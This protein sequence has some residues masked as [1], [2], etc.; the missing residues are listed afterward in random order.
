MK[1]V[2]IPRPRLFQTLETKVDDDIYDKL[3]DRKLYVVVG[4]GNTPYIYLRHQGVTMALARFVIGVEQHDSLSVD[5]I[6]RDTLDNQRD[7]LRIVT[8]S[9]NLLNRQMRR[10]NG[11]YIYPGVCLLE[12]GRYSARLTIDGKLIC[13]KKFA[14]AESAIAYRKEHE[15]K[16]GIVWENGVIKR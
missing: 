13:R 10:K 1:T 8:R 11:P 9:R 6:N 7:N 5:H 3:L 2:S 4:T 16:H 14:S 15:A 12:D